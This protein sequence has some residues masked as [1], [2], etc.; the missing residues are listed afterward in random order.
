MGVINIK[1]KLPKFIRLIHRD[2]S[3]LFAGVILVYA[4]SG[5]TMNHYKGFN[6]Q[7]SIE[8]QNFTIKGDYPRIPASY[9]KKELLNILDALGERNNYTRYYSPDEK[10]VKIFMKEGS[11]LTINTKSGKALYE[12]VKKR[13]IVSGLAFLHYNPNKWWTIFSDIFAVSLIVI[14][15]TGIFITKGAKG[16]IGTGGIKLAIGILIPILFLLLA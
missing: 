12:S 2:L 11:S 14:T 8:Q 4:I 10:T 7:Y 15:F 16:L 3:F 9:S 6:A 1:K 5:I 13:P